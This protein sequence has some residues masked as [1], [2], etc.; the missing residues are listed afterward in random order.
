MNSLLR[1]DTSTIIESDLD[2]IIDIMNF[3]SSF[4][5]KGYTADILKEIH[6][7][8]NASEIK[9]TSK[10]ISLHVTNA[11]RLAH[12]GF[13]STPETSFL[14]LYYSTLNLIK[15]YLL[16]KKRRVDLSKNRWH[17][18][19]YKEQEMNK[20]FLNEKIIIKSK[21][22]I[23]LYYNTIIGETI[24]NS[25]FT[26]TLKELYQNISTISAEYTMITKQKVGFMAHSNIFIEDKINGHYL[27]LRIGSVYQANNAPTA[28]KIKA[29]PGLKRIKSQD[30]TYHYESA[31]IKGEF[32]VAKRKLSKNVIRHLLSDTAMNGLIQ[33]SWFS[34]TPISGREHVFNEEMSIMLAYFHLS[35]I[36]RYNPEHL[37]KLMDSKYWSIIL[38]LRMHGFLRFEKLMYG[39]FIEKSFEIK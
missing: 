17:G 8:N 27:K 32:E 13:E 38:G 4:K 14:L 30:G 7:F 18:A 24:P 28:I 19:V 15:V 3:I 31:R 35:N 16:I 2:P 34:N 23:P 1:H 22:T 36:I 29:Y 20:Q 5:S 25:G 37:Y 9:K 12:Q 39:N 10:L 33:H 11:E 6:G 21:G 26:I